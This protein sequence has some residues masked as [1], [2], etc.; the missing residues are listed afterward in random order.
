MR[1]DAD[2]FALVCGGNLFL[3]FVIIEFSLLKIKYELFG[4]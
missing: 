4:K 1:F 2:V 3:S